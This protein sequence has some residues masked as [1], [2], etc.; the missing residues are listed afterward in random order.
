PACSSRPPCLA[1]LNA[2]GLIV[3]SKP[4]ASP[5]QIGPSAY[6]ATGEVHQ[7]LVNYTVA[8][9]SSRRCLT[10]LAAEHGRWGARTHPGVLAHTR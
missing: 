7:V 4:V 10:S 1:D 3:W 8:V 9:R 5:K 6:R 2:V